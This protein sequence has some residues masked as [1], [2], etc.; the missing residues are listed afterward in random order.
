M[1]LAQLFAAVAAADYDSALA[2]YERLL[3]RPAD[4]FPKEN[5][6]V[7]QVAPTGWIYL[8]G[9]AS[10]AGNALL[11]IMVD[12]LEDQVSELAERGLAAEAIE[13]VPELFRRAQINDPDG[14]MITF[15]EDLSTDAKT[16]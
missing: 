1:A 6:A 15:A 16:N 5:E 14:N 2:W 4:F 7:W 13:T 3:G 9:D 12:D 8:V 10:R 11:T